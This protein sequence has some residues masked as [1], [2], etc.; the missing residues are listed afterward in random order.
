MSFTAW[1][2]LVRGQSAPWT[3]MEIESAREFRAAVMTISLKRAEE[4]VELSEARFQQLTHA[5]P[6]L[7]WT[8]DDDGQ[9]TYVN[10]KWRDQ[11]LGEQ[12]RW[13]EQ[14]RLV[15]EDQKRCSDLWK[16]AVANGTPFEAE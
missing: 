10:Q 11:G 16:A 12:G 2:E 1:K 15:E 9:L 13:Y 5:L 3:E 6:N 4:A 7:V 14:E 8:A